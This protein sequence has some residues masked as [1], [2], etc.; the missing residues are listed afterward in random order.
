[1]VNYYLPKVETPNSLK[2]EA[3]KAFLSKNDILKYL[4]SKKSIADDAETIST[5]LE[6]HERI[7]YDNLSKVNNIYDNEINNLE[8][9]I[10]D[11]MTNIKTVKR[12]L[13]SGDTKTA[14]LIIDNMI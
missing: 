1:M 13:D 11:I 10:D 7:A 4:Y 12:L 3:K 6:R 5:Y 14:S 2:E 9:N 8:Q